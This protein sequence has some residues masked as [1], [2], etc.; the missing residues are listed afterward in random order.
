VF[1]VAEVPAEL[2]AR[3][4]AAGA[5]DD[6]VDRMLAAGYPRWKVD[7]S[8]SGAPFPTIDMW[9][10]ELTDRERF[11]TG[12]TVRMA[13]WEDDERL[14][15]L[16]ANS[17]ERLGDWD[18][19]VERSPNPFAQH[20]LQ[21]NAQVRLIVDRGVALGA[22]A[23]AG[24]SSLVGGQRLSVAWIGG[25]RVRNGFRRNG[26]AGMLLST[27]GP[28]S[29]VFG[30]LTYWY[31]RFENGTAHEW[32]AGRVEGGD[33]VGTRA[34]GKL[35]ATVHHLDPAAGR[36]DPRVRPITPDDVPRCV[37]LI[38]ATHAGLDLFRPFRA[39]AFEDRLHDLFW[40]S[41]RS[42]RTCTAGPTW[43]CSTTTARSWLAPAC[44]TG[45]ATCASAGG[46]APPARSA[47]STPPASWTSATRPDVPT[48]SPP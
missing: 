2:R 48:R 9:I 7:L 8:V 38:N 39:D 13:T 37:E 23:Q 25:W 41:H 31:V 26:Y 21:D 42:C 20:R 19:F 47:P 36:T 6:L 43:P 28:A 44:G 30:M 1:T 27:P 18:V 3:A 34:M 15:D 16:F 33:V 40:G 11:S 4:A 5:P 45:G 29:G 10:A 46:T 35:T 32:I 17:S 12:L 24:R 14:S 22:S